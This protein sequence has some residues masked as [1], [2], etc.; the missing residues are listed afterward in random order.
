MDAFDLIKEK[1]AYNQWAN[2]VIMAWL[3]QH[4]PDLYV[5]EVVSSFPTINKLMHHIMETEKYYFSILEQREEQYAENMATEEIFEELVQIDEALLGWLSTQNSGA[6]DKTIFLKRSPF[7]ETYSTAT[8]IT[9]LVNHST[10]H[11]GQLVALRNQLKMS[12]AP[13]TD[14][15]RFIISTSS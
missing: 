13:K 4:S 8:I 10:Y 12:E 9:H 3:Q 6:M 1:L 7:L 2:K 14:H 5:K 15:Y 11:R